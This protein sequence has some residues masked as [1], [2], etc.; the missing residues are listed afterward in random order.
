[1]KPSRFAAILLA[2]GKSSRMG[3][4]KGLLPW[5]G[6]S[7]I[8]YQVEQLLEAGFDQIIVVLGYRSPLLEQEIKGYPVTIVKNPH[9]EVGKSSSIR[10]G[11][12]S[13]QSNIKG[14]MITAVDQPVPSMTLIQMMEAMNKQDGDIIIPV[15]Q[16]KRGHPV[17]FNSRLID[18]LLQVNEKTQGLKKVIHN[19]YD[20]ITY[21][22]VKDPSVLLNLNR[23]EDYNS[24][25]NSAE[26]G[27]I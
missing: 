12:T 15:Y 14:I 6:K 16:E 9:F 7:L 13:I 2:A 8:Q 20:R 11:V 23:P 26:G 17:L 24:F 21:L 18:D 1:M 10:V 5:Q 4:L 22:E 25:I 19:Y 3:K 27:S